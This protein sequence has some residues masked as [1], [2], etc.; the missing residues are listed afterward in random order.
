MMP[1]STIEGAGY[2]YF[3]DKEL[4]VQQ[5]PDIDDRV[6][7]LIDEFESDRQ[8]EFDLTGEDVEIEIPS[9]KSAT[10]P[11][12]AGGI[13]E[14]E[15][16]NTIYRL[17][18]RLK[19]LG[20]EED[21]ILEALN[22]IN[23]TY[24]ETPLDDKVVEEKAKNAA[25]LKDE[26][27]PNITLKVRKTKKIN[28]QWPVEDPPTVASSEEASSGSGFGPFLDE[29]IQFS[30][31]RSPEAYDLYH[32]AC[33]LFV[34]STIAARRFAIPK[35]K[36][37]YP[38]LYL[39]LIGPSGI[40]AKSTT[41]SVAKDVVSAAGA[42]KYLIRWATP[43]RLVQK[44]AEDDSSGQRALV[45]GEIGGLVRELGQGERFGAYHSLLRDLYDCEKQYSRS[46]ISRQDEKVSRPYLSVIGTAT[47]ADFI[48]V[49]HRFSP[50]WRDG[51]LARFLLAAPPLNQPV[52]TETL[53]SH[54]EPIP[55]TLVTKLRDWD[56]RL[57][58]PTLVASDP[59]IVAEGQVVIPQVREAIIDWR[60][61]EDA[62]DQYR[63]ELRGLFNNREVHEDLTA[64]YNRFP[65]GAL[66]IA[67]LVASV[68]GKDVIEM[69][70]W[71][72]ALRVVDQFRASL[73]YVHQQ[74]Q[75]GSL[76]EQQQ[77]I[78]TAAVRIYTFL[79][80]KKNSGK[81]PEATRG[82]I[83]NNFGRA[84]KTVPEEIVDDACQYLEKLGVIRSD[85]AKGSYRVFLVN[86]WEFS[87]L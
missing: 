2:S 25:N 36:E 48:I 1:P 50:F 79:V 33:G 49:A 14:G 24:C 20:W 18:C 40:F 67:A 71:E 10:V 7:G 22:Q 83:V 5:I 16:D 3:Q 54:L 52:I 84:N 57:G 6:L 75:F 19:G 77:A 82:Q 23:Q 27:V 80:G 66:K 87:D 86:E 59:E 44:M 61:V 60:P 11:I 13:P 64:T 45:F 4:D 26:P 39:V 28:I 29:Y 32:L 9:G 62:Y 43:E 46:T 17:G 68:E 21:E 35:G 70:D 42:E 31:R 63:R 81:K 12:P 58:A 74:C 56:G 53:G 72:I 38:N 34:L 47:P 85:D 65:D 51:F 37:F 8:S 69:S 15:R 41:A 30:R 78:H 76:A 55:E 73:H